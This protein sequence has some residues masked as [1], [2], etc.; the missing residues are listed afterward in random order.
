MASVVVAHGGTLGGHVEP[1]LL[2]LGL[3][4]VVLA[5]LLRPSQTGTARG[6]LITLVIGV[7]LILGSF[8]LPRL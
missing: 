2:V 7:A 5:F 1:E 3:V 8:T 6:S 4:L